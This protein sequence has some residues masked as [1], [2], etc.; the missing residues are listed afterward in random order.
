MPLP[1]IQNPTQRCQG[2]ALPSIGHPISR[3]HLGPT[4]QCFDRGHID[5][6]RQNLRPHRNGDGNFFVL[7]IGCGRNAFN[8][9]QHRFELKCD[10]I[11]LPHDHAACS[12]LNGRV[13]TQREQTPCHLR[14]PLESWRRAQS[15]DV[16][17]TATA[18][19]AVNEYMQ[20]EFSRHHDLL[21]QNQ[22]TMS[23]P[24]NPSGQRP[25]GLRSQSKTKRMSLFE[26]HQSHPA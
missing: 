5:Q 10:G 15:I 24:K 23:G 20:G 13:I 21:K 7:P 1:I 25:T 14:S 3:R 17:G 4:R 9:I 26:W 6:A 19:S 12:Q 8:F 16:V 2:I 22:S 18:Q 11:D